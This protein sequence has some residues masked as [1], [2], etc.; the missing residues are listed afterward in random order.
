M[1]G[2]WDIGKARIIIQL[3]GLSWLVQMEQSPS[4]NGHMY[5]EDK[6]PKFLNIVMFHGNIM[7][8]VSLCQLLF[9]PV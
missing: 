9:F 1:K 8:L 3:S 4:Y 7:L 5:L 6:F 2:I